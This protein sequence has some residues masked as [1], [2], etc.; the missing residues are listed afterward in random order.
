MRKKGKRE[1][2]VNWGAVAV[3]LQAVERKVGILRRKVGEARDGGAELAEREFK[4]RM[5]GIYRDLNWA[6]NSRH[7][8]PFPSKPEEMARRGRFPE[9]VARYKG[10]DG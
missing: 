7:G 1:E 4:R 9:G 10:E 8:E 2:R 6:W 3:F 5:G